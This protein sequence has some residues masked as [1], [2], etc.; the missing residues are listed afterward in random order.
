MKKFIPLIFIFLVMHGLYAYPEIDF[1]INSI[2]E[3]SGFIESDVRRMYLDRQGFL[4]IATIDNLYR[5]DGY[6]ARIPG[7][8]GRANQPLIN[9][10]VEC[11]AEASEELI[12]IG[13]KTGLIEFNRKTYSYRE[14][15]SFK[16]FDIVSIAFD[17]TRNI[18]WIGTQSGLWSYN[19]SNAK[20]SHHEFKNGKSVLADVQHLIT[21]NNGQVWIACWEKG[22]YKFNPENGQFDV[23]PPTG[24]FNSPHYLFQ[25][26]KGII[27]IGTWK[28]GLFSFDPSQINK[29]ITYRQIKAE[30]ELPFALQSSIIYSIAQDEQF[31]YL[32]I[33]GRNGLSILKDVNNPYSFYNFRETKHP[34]MGLISS[35]DVNAI[36]ISKTNG[37]VWLGIL[38]G[39]V[40]KV[41]LQNKKFGKL[42]LPETFRE[43]IN[44][45]INKIIPVGGNKLWLSVPRKFILEMQ[46]DKP[47]YKF[48]H[49]LIN[50]D[51]NQFDGIFA[52]TQ[53]AKNEFLF[54][55]FDGTIIRVWFDTNGNLTKKYIYPFRR[56][57]IVAFVKYGE[58][59]LFANKTK[60]GIIKTNGETYFFDTNFLP[61]SPENI[62]LTDLKTD[63]VG[64][65]WISTQNKGIYKARLS[66]DN[67]ALN[68]VHHYSLS[69]QGGEINGA[70][71]LFLDN[72]DR[73][74]AGSNGLGLLLFDSKNENF[75]VQ[76]N[77]IIL[78]NYKNV[79]D[80]IEDKNNRLWIGTNQGIY[81]MKVTAECNF[82]DVNVFDTSDGLLSAKS[83]PRSF[84]MSNDSIL[85]FGTAGGVNYLTYTKTEKLNSTASGVFLTSLKIN[86]RDFSTLPDK[87]R[88]RISKI[89]PT[90]SK[91]IKLRYNENNI[92][93]E[94]AS[95]DY[96]RPRQL[97]YAYR[98]EGLENEWVI[99]NYENR[100][101][102]YS[103]LKPGDYRLLVK[104]SDNHLSWSEVYELVS[105]EITPPWWD[106]IWAY[107]VYISI[108]LFVIVYF[109]TLIRHQNKLRQEVIFKDL[110]KKTMEEIAQTKLQFFTNISHE[111]LTP[112]TIISTTIEGLRKK[113]KS[114]DTA[115]SIAQSNVDR[116][117][118]LFEQILEFRKAE[119]RNL[120]LKVSHENLVAFVE[121]LCAKSFKPLAM[122][123]NLH[124]SAVYSDRK[125]E[126]Y[127]DSDKLEKILF[128]LVSNAIKYTPKYGSVQL[129]VQVRE[130]FR[131]VVFFIKDTGIGM[132]EEQLP[133]IFKRFYDGDYRKVKTSGHGIGLSLTKELVLLHHGTIEVSSKVGVGSEFRVEIPLTQDAYLADEIILPETEAI[134]PATDAELEMN[135]NQEQVNLKTLLLVE[136]NEE[137][138]L[139][140]ENLLKESYKIVTAIDGSDAFEKIEKNDIDVV[141]TDILMPVTDGISLC[142]RIKA[143]L[144]YSHIPV[145]LLTAQNTIEDKVKGY[146]A[147]ADGYIAKPFSLMELISKTNA[148]IENKAR[149][150]DTIKNRKDENIKTEH[151]ETIDEKFLKKLVNY[152]EENIA[153]EELD[154][155]ALANAMYVSR[156]VLYRKIK[157]LT[158]AAP[159]DFIRKLRLNMAG[160]LL[161]SGQKNIT[162]VAFEVG[163]YNT[164][165]FS[166]LFKKEFGMSPSE[167]SKKHKESKKHNDNTL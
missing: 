153:R 66:S 116:L 108:I 93:I 46:T 125:I 50:V 54:S 129:T 145:V 139:S 156:S 106:N 84:T 61:Q 82:E 141:L 136:D 11:F 103:Y 39:G 24:N 111:L 27:W 142:R 32:W 19:V 157:S 69:N 147:G 52:W 30:P 100:M 96:L 114:D 20:T 95:L 88:Q 16:N 10:T 120:K 48:I 78:P 146:E 1:S 76:S 133:E 164:K 9:A 97:I 161:K 87:Q 165:H 26:K 71:V 41:E 137:L 75:V 21:D 55:T 86:N 56:I 92:S 60:I 159:S 53:L 123:K 138:L 44:F 65:I 57:G 126:G 42:E 8:P 151:E 62:S 167:F 37:V 107:L 112:L 154:I 158:G 132:S 77:K 121:K 152:I 155:D 160:N 101:P 94:F 104:V 67:N 4:W 28:D 148:L 49:Q 150:Y 59:V 83:T 118:K 64:D 34:Q 2:E 163:I 14:I 35:N 115:F 40:E 124:F 31:G 102:N 119:T 117:L 110:E 130:N 109:L 63:K 166:T 131:K 25:D 58:D 23:M 45:R 85:F 128:N 13:T 127:F 149:L 17:S 47:G 36:A 122:Q 22:L 51:T 12:W 90:Y 98:L 135:E 140:M 5:Y 7:M 18:L 74:W 144:R 91:H 80:I 143:D 43:Q 89:N 81:S 38:G 3:E 134:S 68:I 73:L 79:F 162:D 15:E 29:S 105:I 70:N 6:Q 72:S 99:G 113:L 33:G